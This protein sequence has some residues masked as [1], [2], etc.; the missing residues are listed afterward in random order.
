MC[1]INYNT[2]EFIGMYLHYIVVFQN[3]NNIVIYMTAPYQFAQ[4]SSAQLSD[5]IAVYALKC[6]RN[7]SLYIIIILYCTGVSRPSFYFSLA[8]PWLGISLKCMLY[9][10]YIQLQLQCCA[11]F[12]KTNCLQYFERLRSR[13]YTPTTSIL[14][15]IYI[16]I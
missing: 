10:L 15:K 13:G 12:C 4:V 9:Y 14:I 16:I 3:V 6:G 11:F 8:I 5:I 7:V 1:C 2:T